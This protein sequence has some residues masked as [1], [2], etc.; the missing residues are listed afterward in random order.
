MHYIR[1]S[2]SGQVHSFMATLYCLRSVETN[3]TLTCPF[4]K[5]FVGNLPDSGRHVT[6]V[7]QGLSLSRSVG[8]VGVNPGNEVVCI[9]VALYVRKFVAR[10]NKIESTMSRCL[11]TNEIL[12]SI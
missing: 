9:F 4:P 6:S 11:G 7:S 3:L 12:A 10:A 2:R 5:S 1:R 8:R